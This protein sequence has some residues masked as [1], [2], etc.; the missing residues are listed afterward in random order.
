M[1][2]HKRTE[3]GAAVLEPKARALTINET[4]A[5]ACELE[6]LAED[7]ARMRS[8]AARKLAARVLALAE[9]LED[10]ADVA[11]IREAREEMRRTGQKPIPF[12]DVAKKLGL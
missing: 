4:L 3:G 11:A 6:D 12:E 8:E 2:R 10:R 7:L 5:L 1:P 9:D